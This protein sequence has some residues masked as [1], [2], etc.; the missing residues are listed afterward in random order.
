MQKKNIW[1]WRGCILST[2]IMKI[3][4]SIIIE[5]LSEKVSTATLFS[6]GFDLSAPCEKT[7]GIMEIT[8]FTSFLIVLLFYMLGMTK[9]NVILNK[10]RNHAAQISLQRNKNLKDY[11]QKCV[12]ICPNIMGHILY[13]SIIFFSNVFYN[14]PVFVKIATIEIL[15]TKRQ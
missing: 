2:M 14:F 9:P 8:N 10:H 4:P 15:L 13:R 11:L 3:I 7:H 1:E 12:Q 5:K 6:H